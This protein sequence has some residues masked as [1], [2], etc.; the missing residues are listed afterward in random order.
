MSAPAPPPQPA[1]VL[2]ASLFCC[3]FAFFLFGISRYICFRCVVY[4]KLIPDPDTGATKNFIDVVSIEE[5]PNKFLFTV[6]SS[7]GLP[8]RAIVMQVC[9]GDRV[10]DFEDFVDELSLFET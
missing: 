6:E 8:P 4:A 1:L 3:S 9:C 5:R 7:G 2:A 10:F